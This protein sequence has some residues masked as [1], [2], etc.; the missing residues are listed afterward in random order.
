MDAISRPRAALCPVCNGKG[1]TFDYGCIGGGPFI[2]I[3][4]IFE[5]GDPQGITR[6]LCERCLGTGHIHYRRES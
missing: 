3:V 2:W 4:A 5:R 1:H 6:R